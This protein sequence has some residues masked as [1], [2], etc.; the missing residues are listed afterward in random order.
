VRSGPLE[1]PGTN[2]DR[3]RAGPVLSALRL[4]RQVGA[5]DHSYS[6]GKLLKHGTYYGGPPEDPYEARPRVGPEL[7]LRLP[8]YHDRRVHGWRLRVWGVA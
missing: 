1:R 3:T 2:C 8:T 5:G 6:G 4:P 7:H